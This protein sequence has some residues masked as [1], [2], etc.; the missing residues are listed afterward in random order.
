[1][2]YILLSAVLHRDSGDAVHTVVSLL[3]RDGGDAVHTVVS[4]VA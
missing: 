2:L 4:C 3:H 1:M